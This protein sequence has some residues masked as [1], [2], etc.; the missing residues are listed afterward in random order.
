MALCCQKMTLWPGG[1]CCTASWHG[2]ESCRAGLLGNVC[3]E[4]RG[5][6]SRC[7]RPVLAGRPWTK[8]C[9]LPLRLQGWDPL[10]G[11]RPWP[12]SVGTW[13]PELGSAGSQWNIP[14]HLSLS[15]MGTFVALF[16]TRK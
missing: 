3:A 14:H 12:H 5:C 2:A 4:V 8:T 13:C 10:H 9:L 7:L 11:A 15:H 6:P 16:F 1:P